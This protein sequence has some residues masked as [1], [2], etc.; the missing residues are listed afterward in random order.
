MIRFRDGE[1]VG[2]FYS[3]HRDGAAFD[4]DDQSIS[5]SGGRV[6]TGLYPLLGTFPSLFCLS[7]IRPMC[8]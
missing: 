7:N 5:K 1:P 6:R 8:M 3:Q 4:W 2:I